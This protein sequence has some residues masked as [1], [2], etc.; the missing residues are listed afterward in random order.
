MK[1][2]VGLG[3]L[4]AKYANNRH[5][6]GFM[7]ADAIASNHGLSFKIDKD[8]MCFVAKTPEFVLICPTTFMNASGESVRAVCDYFEIESKDVLT[9]HDELDLEFGKI[10]L[11]F[12]GSSAGHRGI[13]SVIKGLSGGDFARLRVGVGRSTPSASDGEISGEKYV[14]SDFS[15]TQKQELPKIIDM[16]VE[17]VKSYLSDGLEATMNKFN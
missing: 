2:I 3:N 5:N 9:I 7:A 10:R 16:C 17:A 13:E 8:L 14:L 6:I 11:S 1:L 15:D 12:G 4:G